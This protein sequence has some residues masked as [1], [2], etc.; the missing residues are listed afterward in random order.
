MKN[1][2]GN[3]DWEI[4]IKNQD[5]NKAFEI[6]HNKLLEILNFACTRKNTLSQRKVNK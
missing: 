4:E 3:I 1:D 2:I 6:F 5:V